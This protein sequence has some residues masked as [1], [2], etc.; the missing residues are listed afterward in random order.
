[1]TIIFCRNRR[2]QPDGNIPSPGNLYDHHDS[3]AGLRGLREI[4]Q[5]QERR[6]C[7][8]YLLSL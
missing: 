7:R 8:L 2:V 5:S 3:R 6:L 4:H 1:M